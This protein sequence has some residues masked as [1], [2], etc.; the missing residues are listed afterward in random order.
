MKAKKEDI[1]K[2]VAHTLSQCELLELRSSLNVL[3]LLNQQIETIEEH[4]TYLVQNLHL[5]EYKILCSIPGIG[6]KSASII[7]SEIG[8]INDFKS[9]AKLCSWAGIVP[10]VYQSAGVLRTGHITK[11]GNKH[12]RWILVECAHS[13]A[14]NRK[15]K[16]YD[17]FKRLE[18]KVGY[19]KAIVALARKLLAL[20]WHLLTNKELFESDG[21]QKNGEVSISGFLKLVNIIG[22]NE[23]LELI[24]TA[25]VQRLNEEKRKERGGV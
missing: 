9:A 8:D 12:L 25:Q 1:K 15:T 10:E 11:M 23:A 14:K 6:H 19:K 7:I 13:C 17:F 5:N 3:D 18:R 4:I 16:L 2:A 24:H 20:I 21:Y 22:E